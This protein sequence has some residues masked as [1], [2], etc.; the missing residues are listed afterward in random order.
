MNKIS[1]VYSITNSKNGKR[2]IGSSYNFYKRKSVHLNDLRKNKHHCISLQRAFNKYKEKN[3]IF[4]ILLECEEWLL[5]KQEKYFFLKLNPEYN[6]CPEPNAPMAGR[7]HKASTLRKFKKRKQIKGPGHHS[8]GKKWTDEVRLKIL[9]AREGFTH[10]EKTKKKMRNTAIKNNQG[11]Y[12]I[13]STQKQ[14]RS[15]IDSLG[16]KFDSL[17][18]CS[19]FHKISVATVC[20]ILKGRHSKTRKGIIFKYYD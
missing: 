1:C 7:K 20:D 5:L 4:T 2:Y 12:L 16:N 15:I 8:Y 6:I 14:R 18:E 19:K 9:K 3:F 11:R 17:V 13:P 10:S